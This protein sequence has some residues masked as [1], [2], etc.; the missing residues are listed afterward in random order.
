MVLREADWDQRI[1]W[2][3]GVKNQ[4]GIERKGHIG[5]GSGDMRMKPDN[6]WVGKRTSFPSCFF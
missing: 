2:G 4:V 1:A 6:S 5:S 3:W